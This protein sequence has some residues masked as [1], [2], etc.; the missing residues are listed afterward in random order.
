[1]SVV[2]HGHVAEVR[3]LLD[4]LRAISRGVE[5]LLTLNSAADAPLEGIALPG[6]GRIIRNRTPRGFGANHNAAFGA[7]SGKYFCVVN[8]DIRLPT[9]PF[10][11]LTDALKRDNVGVAGPRVVDSAGTLQASYRRVPTP[12]LWLRHALGSKPD[13][14]YANPEPSEVD[15]LAGMF[16]LFRHDV[17]ERLG[18]FDERY[19]LYYE[20]V[21]LCCRV[22]IAGW[23]VWLDPRATVI[24]DARRDSHRKLKFTLWHAGSVLR[25]WLSPTFRKIRRL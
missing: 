20:D 7:A 16:L 2:S 13:Y 22:R 14:D 6:P 1:M 12:A 24:H 19:F 9:D 10:G 25:F 8:P 18:G 15:W 17:F 5:V 23:R 3:N 21:E 4:D 11:A